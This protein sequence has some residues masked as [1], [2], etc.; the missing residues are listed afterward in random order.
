MRLAGLS[1]RRLVI[2]IIARTMCENRGIN[3]MLR[4][5]DIRHLKNLAQYA[6]YKAY[7]KNGAYISSNNKGLALCFKFNSPISSIIPYIQGIIFILKSVKFSTLPKIFKLETFKKNQRPANGE[8][9][10]FWFFSV[11]KGGDNAGFELKNGI[12][13]MAR[14]EQLPIYAETSKLRNKIVYERFGF[15]TYHY[16][17]DKINDL[18]YWFMKWGS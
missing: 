12:F 16:Y 7:Y 6:F 3:W 11:V 18:Q 10:Y 5:T 17:E 8:Y 14:K 15:K 9:M 2:D 4:S 13:N 1:D